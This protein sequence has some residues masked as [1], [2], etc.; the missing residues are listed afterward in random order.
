M[1]TPAFAVPSFEALL[2]DGQE[3][4]TAVAQPDRP[5]GRGLGSASPPVAEAARRAGV[6]V[7]QPERVRDPA[8]ID[9]ISRIAPELIVVVA[10]G[11]I[12]PRRLLDV[13]PLGCINLHASLLPRYRGAAPIQWA[14]LRGEKIT[15]VTTMYM[16]ERMDEGD[17]LLTRELP[18]LPDETAGALSERLSRLGPALLVETVR[19]LAA[20]T[21]TGQ[22]QDAA[23][24]TL[25]PRLQKDD[26]RIRWA[27]GAG[28]ILNRIRAVTPWPGA[29]TTLGT[30]QLKIWGAGPAD[31]ESAGAAPGTVLRADAGGIV[32]AAGDG[33]A[34]A[35]R[36]LQVAGK[37]RLGAGAFLRGTRLVAGAV[38]GMA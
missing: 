6:Q 20:G 17:I 9:A 11:Q 15:G 3:I 27:E 37:R 34:V 7:L 23:R 2:A 8:F 32:V 22:A 36:E 24:A 18:I 10:F 13:P 4:A 29:F 5:R 1:G 31:G 35:V 33:G 26:G 30:R 21:V 14:I 16:N 12:L 25:A 28:E 38:L 19:G